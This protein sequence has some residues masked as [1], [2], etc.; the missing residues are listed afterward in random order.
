VKFPYLLRAEQAKAL[1]ILQQN[2]HLILIASTGSGKSLVFQKY[3]FDQPGVRAVLISPLNALS[4]QQA[5]RFK[6]LGIKVFYHEVPEQGEPGVWIMSPEKVQGRTMEYLKNW[7]PEF[8]IVDEAHC[9]W[10]WG[11][12]F[13]PAYRRILQL[14]EISSIQKSLWCSATLP[15][16]FMTQLISHLK[17]LPRSRVVRLGKFSLP[18]SLQLRK[19]KISPELRSLWLRNQLGSYADQSGMIFC[20]IFLVGEYDQFIIT[21]V[22]L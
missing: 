12:E 2:D 21:Q 6:K 19:E 11:R 22:F 1:Q 4:R 13:R 20:N 17:K 9:V 14:S 7:R 16:S 5:E 8:L 18:T 15:I 3:L 10:E